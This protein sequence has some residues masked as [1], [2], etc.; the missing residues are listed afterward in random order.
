MKTVS[1]KTPYWDIA[2]DVHFPPGFN[3]AGK[4]PAIISA[5][6][7]GSCKEQTSG[8]VYGEALAKEGFVEP[9]NPSRGAIRRILDQLADRA[10]EVQC[11]DPADVP[12][13]ARD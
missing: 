11:A 1:I 10:D 12:H 5:H 7:I 13:H 3:E 8:N 4:Y 9:T 2:A 6:P